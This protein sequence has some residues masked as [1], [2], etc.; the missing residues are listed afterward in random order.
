MAIDFPRASDLLR[1]ELQ[2][3]FCILQQATDV[4]AQRVAAARLQIAVKNAEEFTYVLGEEQWRALSESQRWG[5]LRL[6]CYVGTALHELR[7]LRR[8]ARESQYSDLA[9]SPVRQGSQE[10]QYA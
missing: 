2:A 9:P 1:D 10:V 4:T 7:Q 3:F 5:Y 8:M 6:E